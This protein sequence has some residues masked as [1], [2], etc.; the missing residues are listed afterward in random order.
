MRPKDKWKLEAPK[1]GDAQ[2]KNMNNKTH[3]WRHTNMMWNVH[4]PEY[5]EMGK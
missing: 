2:T 3:H 4:K 1:E 5:F